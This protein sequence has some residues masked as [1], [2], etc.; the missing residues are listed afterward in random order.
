MAVDSAQ[1]T[2]ALTSFVG[3]VSAKC[4]PFLVRDI[5]LSS[6]Q[7]VPVQYALKNYGQVSFAV[8][9]GLNKGMGI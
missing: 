7:C 6:F 4:W 1:K 9:T 8:T 5:M 3:K 2:K